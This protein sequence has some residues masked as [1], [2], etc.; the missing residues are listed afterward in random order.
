MK[1]YTWH[2][3]AITTFPHMAIPLSNPPSSSSLQLLIKP[4][5]SYSSLLDNS[6]LRRLLHCSSLHR[7]LPRQPK[8]SSLRKH[9]NPSARFP[10][11]LCPLSTVFSRPAHA[12]KVLAMADTPTQSTSHS[13][14]YTNRLAAEHSPYLLQHAHNPV[15]EVL[16]LILIVFISIGCQAKIRK[17]NEP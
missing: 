4:S 15:S 13:H 14:K 3:L 12:S 10:S 7:L 2:L 8:L 11:F 16:F 9:A 6:M 1:S 17:R 5:L